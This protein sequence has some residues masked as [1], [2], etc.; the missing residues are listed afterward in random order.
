MNISDDEG[1]SKS[2]L[3]RPSPREELARFFQEERERKK[4]KSAFNKDKLLSFFGAKKSEYKAPKDYEPID[5]SGQTEYF[6]SMSCDVNH[7]YYRCDIIHVN[8]FQKD[9]FRVEA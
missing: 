6:E 9:S 4:E 8:R 5:S 2:N 7:G 3:N 1:T